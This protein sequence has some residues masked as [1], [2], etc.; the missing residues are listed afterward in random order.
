DDVDGCWATAIWPALVAIQTAEATGRAIARFAA[1]TGRFTARGNR[2][3]IGIAARQSAY[4]CALGART[5]AGPAR[6]AHGRTAGAGP[7]KFRRTRAH[8]RCAPG[9]VCLAN[10]HADGWQSGADVGTYRQD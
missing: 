4:C 5:G 9:R 7:A 2:Y 8:R 10:C 6:T 1:G 3:S